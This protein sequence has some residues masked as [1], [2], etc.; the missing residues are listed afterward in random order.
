MNQA[1]HK[2]GLMHSF[3]FLM[4]KVRIH[5]M[6]IHNSGQSK[7]L[8][9]Q[10][11]KHFLQCGYSWWCV[12]IIH[13]FSYLE[14]ECFLGLHI[15]QGLNPSAQIEMKFYSQQ[16]DPVQGNYVCYCV[17]GA[18]AVVQY[19]QFEAFFC[20]QYPSKIPPNRKD[21]PMYKV[22]SISKHTQVI[23]MR[24]WRLGRDLSGD[25]QTIGFQ[26]KYKDKL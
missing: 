14:I 26:G 5:K 9:G 11:N 17:F 21:H 8:F 7:G 23:S 2:I 10:I 15:L 22:D 18:N 19:K 1:N 24:A 6:S 4:G 13:P 3:Q 12:S 16:M 20:V 25:E